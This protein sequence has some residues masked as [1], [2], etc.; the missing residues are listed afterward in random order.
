MTDL[1]TTDLDPAPSRTRPTT[2]ST[3]MDA[4]LGKLPAWTT[5]ANALATGANANA[6][7]AA[8]SA[9]DAENAEASSVAAANFKGSWSA[10]TGALNVPASV[11]HDELYWMLLS[12]LANV[13]AKEPGV[14]A[15]W[16]QIGEPDRPFRIP[17]WPATITYDTGKISTVVY[18]KGTERYRETMGYTG[19]KLTSDIIAYSSNSGGDYTNLGTEGYVYT[20]EELTSTT[21]TAA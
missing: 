16:A 15:E 6:V 5:E 13:T 14:D 18:A 12:N 21:W 19:E 8:Q 4:F 11:Y 2:F 10:L 3:E 20:G 17:N 7:A 1:I 9:A